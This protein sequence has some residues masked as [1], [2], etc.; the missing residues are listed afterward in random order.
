[1]LRGMRVLD[2]SQ[3]I[4]GPFAG[5]RLAAMGAE[6]IKIEPLQGD[7]VRTAGLNKKE[8]EALYSAYNRL[9]KSI[10][11]NLKTTEGVELA[12]KLIKYSDVVLES[13][14][15][16]VM[17]RLGINYE[18]LQEEKEDLIYCSIRGYGIEGK[19]SEM[20]SHDL[21]Y[22]A[23]S[24][25]LSQMNDSEGRPVLP[26]LTIADLTGGLMAVEAIL[27]ALFQRERTGKGRHISISLLDAT[28][29]LM[30]GHLS[31]Y[32]SAG[33]KRG[34]SLLT[35]DYLCYH[36]YQTGD[37]RYMALAALEE[38]FWCQFCDGV[39]HP[40]WYSVGFTRTVDTNPFYRA[41]KEL[42]QSRTFAEW[43]K[44]AEETDCCL[45]PVLDVDELEKGED[46]RTQTGSSGLNNV[47]ETGG[48]TDR[49][50]ADLL[51]FQEEEIEKLKERGVIGS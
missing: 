21:N 29:N 47:P 1:M 13:F 38:K 45:T 51:N 49:I 12:K 24:G 41:M 35:G 16:G 34:V 2:F 23:L 32:R 10:A 48:D 44:F 26:R 6:V 14:R 22:L 33:T 3:Y 42:F 43:T 25:M 7:P 37:R 8:G 9:K 30:E 27:A 28:K 15:P 20:G 19:K 31:I 5:M 18:Q 17:Q 50:L 39:D 40:E 11:I 36:I 4:P 46:R